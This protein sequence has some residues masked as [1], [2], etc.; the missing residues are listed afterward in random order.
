MRHIIITLLASFSVE[1]L[2]ANQKEVRTLQFDAEQLS[3]SSIKCE[4]GSIYSQLEYEGIDTK[5]EEPGM[6]ELP[7]CYLNVP[8]PLG[9]TNIDVDVQRKS[10]TT[11]EL[12]YPIFPAQEQPTT[13]LLS[14]EPEFTD[15]NEEIYSKETLFPDK[16]ASLAWTL[17][18]V[19]ISNYEPHR[20]SRTAHV[21]RYSKLFR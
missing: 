4:N 9:A 10:I 1:L 12:D 7:I 8:L 21:D 16:A 3:I 11:F 5:L 17:N 6:P 19:Y 2:A 15:S 13:S 18:S 20:L 14:S